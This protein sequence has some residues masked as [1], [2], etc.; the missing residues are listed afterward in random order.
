LHISGSVSGWNNK[1]CSPLPGVAME[2]WQTDEHGRYAPRNEP[3]T[4]LAY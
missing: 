2:L 4:V 1:G 3:D